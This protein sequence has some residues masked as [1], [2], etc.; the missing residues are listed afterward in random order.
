MGSGT[1][2]LV[3]ELIRFPSDLVG[4]RCAVLGELW[5]S[6]RQ[7]NKVRKDGECE[8]VKMS[9]LLLEGCNFQHLGLASRVSVETVPST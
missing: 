2:A 8:E 9:C 4:S 3:W 5:E 6:H 7:E 1:Y